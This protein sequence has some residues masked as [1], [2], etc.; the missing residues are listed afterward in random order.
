MQFECRQNISTVARIHLECLRNTSNGH[1]MSSDVT[2]NTRLIV[3]TPG[4]AQVVQ[5]SLVF[6]IY[7]L[8][9]SQKTLWSG[10]LLNIIVFRVFMLVNALT[11]SVKLRLY[12]S[13][14]YCF[15][16]LQ[17]EHITKFKL[18]CKKIAICNNTTWEA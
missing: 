4:P 1:R 2:D 17:E 10:V 14:N 13:L 8:K 12:I 18:Y 5:Y 9:K 7:L 3:Q 6:L 15:C 11:I 16:L